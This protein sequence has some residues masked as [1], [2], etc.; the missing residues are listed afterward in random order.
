MWDT[1]PGF[2]IG[3]A[4]V[5][6]Q[7]LKI[8]NI[9]FGYKNFSDI[10]AC[11][12]TLNNGGIC[13]WRHG[14]P[15]CPQNIGTADPR[16]SARDWLNDWGQ[17]ARQY[18]AQYPKAFYEPINE[19]NYGGI[20]SDSQL[21]VIYWWNEWMDE[22]ITQARLQGM[23]KLVIPTFGPGHGEPT[24]YRIWKDTINQSA[25]YGNMMGE[26][27]YTPY[28]EEGLC[29][30][31]EWLACRHRTN[32]EYRLAEDIVTMVAITEAAKGWGNDPVDVNDFVCFY[33][34]IRND[35]WLHSVSFWLAGYHPTWPNAN[36]DLYMIPIATKL[37]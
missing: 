31:D 21:N 36:L 10:N 28:H 20:N 8:K 18:L 26:H 5:S 22:Y 30:C 17:A 9:G 35:Y 32:Q 11:I 2:N 3:N 15:D 19:C 13:I 27:A 33:Q 23:P 12:E 6:H 7:I 24:Q 37:Q 16:Q 29:A 4:R 1:V 14:N 25:M 34:K